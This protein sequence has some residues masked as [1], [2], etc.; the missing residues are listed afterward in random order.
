[1]FSELMK[2]VQPLTHQ[3]LQHQLLKRVIYILLCG[4]HKIIKQ[5]P[6]TTSTNFGHQ[7]DHHQLEL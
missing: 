2:F 7:S 1:M 5:A 3:T 4:P 6:T